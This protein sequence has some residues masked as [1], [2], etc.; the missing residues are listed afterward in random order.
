MR[1]W[2]RFKKSYLL[3]SFKRD[4]IAMISFVVLS[5]LND[6]QYSGPGDC[7]IQYL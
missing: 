3:Y 2:E 7:T 6:H 1:T 5:V 4:P